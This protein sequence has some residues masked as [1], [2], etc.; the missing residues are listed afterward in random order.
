MN[1]TL[2]EAGIAAASHDHDTDYA[3]LSH[4]HGWS[5][6][7][8][9]IPTGPADGDDD[10]VSDASDLCPD[11]AEG[12]AV[13]ALG[14]DDGARIVLR[15]VNFKTDSAELTE[16]S[17][18]ILDGVTVD[19]YGTQTPLNQLASISVPESTTLVIQPWDAGRI[20][21]IEKAIQKANIGLNPTIQGKVVRLIMPELS[22]E[23][24]HEF[25]KL[26]HKMAEH[27][28]VAVRHVRRRQMLGKLNFLV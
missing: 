26:A 6:L 18:A 27:G 21:P 24:R 17:L 19:Y 13:D 14:C 11:T 9:G 16:E 15:G 23:R 3:A 4:D 20:H 25:V 7:V 8:S 5:D 10:G 2:A 28:R 22:E 12:A 1:A